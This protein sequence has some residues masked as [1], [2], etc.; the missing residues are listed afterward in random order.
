MKIEIE[1][2]IVKHGWKVD[3]DEMICGMFSFDGKTNRLRII[4]SLADTVFFL[5]CPGTRQRMARLEEPKY[6]PAQILCAEVVGDK[7]EFRFALSGYKS[8]KSG[9]EAAILESRLHS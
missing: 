5:H 6:F 2:T 3:G 7:L 4:K 8:L 9:I 1:T